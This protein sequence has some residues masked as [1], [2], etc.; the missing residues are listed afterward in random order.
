MIFKEK[1]STR[2]R[3]KH[4]E[5]DKEITRGY[6]SAG[7]D[8]VLNQENMQLMFEDVIREI[9]IYGNDIV[10]LQNRFVSPLSKIGNLI[11]INI[12]LPTLSTSA[13]T[14]A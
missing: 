5:A 10:F 11:S 2:I 9:D 6:R 14:N 4:P 12:I 7:L 3:S 8:E 13:T 1:V